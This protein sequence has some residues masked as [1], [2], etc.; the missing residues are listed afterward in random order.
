M[1][2]CS[3]GGEMN[4]R[5]SD[6][7]GYLGPVPEISNRED[8]PD[9]MRFQVANI[10]RNCGLCPS[11]IRIKPRRIRRIRW[12]FNET[13]QVYVVGDGDKVFPFQARA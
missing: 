12:V 2:E 11:A 3:E 10:A 6:R 7:H 4:R 1:K 9:F 8:A 5:L 13:F